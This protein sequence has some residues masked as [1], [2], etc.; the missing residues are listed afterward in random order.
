MTWNDNTTH[1]LDLINLKKYVIIN[2]SYKYLW[3]YHNSLMS[4]KFKIKNT[5]MSDEIQYYGGAFKYVGVVKN[6]KNSAIWNYMM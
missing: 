5:G 4:I 2:S 6:K 1:D 3:Q